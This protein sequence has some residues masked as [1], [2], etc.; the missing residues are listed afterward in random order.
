MCQLINDL[1]KLSD[2]AALFDYLRAGCDVTAL[3]DRLAA[4]SAV[5][6]G[7]VRAE[8]LR[9]FR[10]AIVS[11]LQSNDPSSLDKLIEEADINARVILFGELILTLYA[12]REARHSG[13]RVNA[14]LNRALQLARDLARAFE[15][16]QSQDRDDE[17]LLAHGV[18]MREWAH[19]LAGYYQAADLV[20][21]TA[22]MLM[23]RA[24]VTNSTLSAWPHLVG[25]AMIDLAV[26]LE[27]IG[28]VEL[29]INCCN[30][31]RM[32]LQ[33]LVDRVDDPALPEFEKVAALY[34]LQRACEEF[35]RLVPGDPNAAHQLQ[36][37]RD[38]RKERGYADAVSAPRFGPI[39]RTYLAK[40]PYLA[41]IIRDLQ[42]NSESVPAICQRYGCP[43]RDVDF[44]L[45]AMGSYV[46]RDTI[47]R[48]ARAYYDEAHQEV[49]AA[50][51]YLRHQDHE[52]GE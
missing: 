28:K 26:A 49:F 24:R 32:D 44:Y 8:L 1:Y 34:W 38:L 46:I 7:T 12:L 51:D 31:I 29:A 21:P 27:P 11:A 3:A 30:G 48:G 39:A 20:G 14:I 9:A 41:L 37:V 2:N 25:S 45:S 16:A 10:D 18:A 15:A 50:I 33:Y 35:C 17:Q 5:P 4:S 6:P 52:K 47:L 40:T 19:L 43:S 36:S 22:E 13:Q 42:T 23:I